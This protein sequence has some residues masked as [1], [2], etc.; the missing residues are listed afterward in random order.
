MVVIDSSTA[1]V[2]RS[3]MSRGVP[4]FSCCG[5]LPDTVDL[6]PQIGDVLTYVPANVEGTTIIYPS[7]TSG[8]MYE[9]FASGRWKQ[10]PDDSYY[11]GPEGVTGPLVA[12]A[13]WTNTKFGAFTYRFGTS[14]EFIHAGSYKLVQA[15]S[16]ADLYG[17]FSDLLSLSRFA[18]N[19]GTMSVIV[20]AV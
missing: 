20:R 6:N 1:G 12:E 2:W 8:K 10:D 13:P 7:A 17:S 14:G 3:S 4:L 16:S 11:T 19:S 15:T 9:I 5:S 18:N